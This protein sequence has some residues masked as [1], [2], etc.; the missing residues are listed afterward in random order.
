MAFPATNLADHTFE[1]GVVGEVVVVVVATTTTTIPTAVAATPEAAATTTTTAATGIGRT[2][3]TTAAL[4]CRVDGGVGAAIADLTALF[5]AHELSLELWERNR[6]GTVC[7]RR[8]NRLELLSNTH[9][10]VGDDL[11]VVQLLAR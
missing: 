2:T 8:C 10:D 9:E 4:F 5:M 7:N 6:V 11:I 3:T 1:K